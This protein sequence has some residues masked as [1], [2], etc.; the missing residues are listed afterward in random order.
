MFEK[1]LRM[2]NYIFSTQDLLSYNIAN[3]RG[4]LGKAF[5]LFQAQKHTFKKHLPNKRPNNFQKTKHNTLFRKLLKLSYENI[6]G[7]QLFTFSGEEVNL[8]LSPG[9]VGGWPLLSSSKGGCILTLF[10][11]K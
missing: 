6:L 10:F 3:S 5:S 9:G 8:L 4:I 11:Y 1:I 2:Q 7:K